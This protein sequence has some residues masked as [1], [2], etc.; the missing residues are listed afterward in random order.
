[1][2]TITYRDAT[3]DDCEALSSLMRETFVATF[4]HLY[5]AEDL[6]AFLAASYAPAQQYAEII[7]MDGETRLAVRDGGLIGYAQIGPFTLPYDPGPAHALELYR[8]Y[9]RADVQGKGVAPT[10]MDW[11]MGRFAARG[12]GQAFLGVWSENHRAQ[13][14][15]T[16][17]GFAKVAEYQFS[18]GEARDAEWILRVD[19][20]SRDGTG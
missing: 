19:L 15:Y 1:M 12:A 17:Y 18:V 14:F 10:L 16:R 8:L 13:K 20:V 9:V 3:V 5:R 4:G 11:A 6:A 7:A 2:S